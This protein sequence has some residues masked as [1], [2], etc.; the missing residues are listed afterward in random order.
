MNFHYIEIDLPFIFG[1][2][3]SYLLVELIQ[4]YKYY[5][6]ENQLISI[7]DKNCFFYTYE[8]IQ[9]RLP[10]SRCQLDTIIKNLKMKN[11][12]EV[13]KKG[14]PARNYFCLNF[15]I[16]DSLRETYKLECN[17]PTLYKVDMSQTTKQESSIVIVENSQTITQE[18]DDNI[19]NY[20]L[21]NNNNNDILSK[22]NKILKEK[23]I[24]EHLFVDSIYF[25][26]YELFLDHAKDVL[27]KYP[28]VDIKYYFD[29]IGDYEKKGGYKKTDWIGVL[30]TWIRNDIKNKD[31]AKIKEVPKVETKKEVV[32]KLNPEGKRYFL[33]HLKTHQIEDLF[34]RKNARNILQE[35]Y[36][37]ESWIDL[38][39]L[40][41][42]I[43]PKNNFKYREIWERYEPT[44]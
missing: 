41:D 13:F 27:I 18:T 4:K 3:E 11:V 20:L 15:S 5:E 42:S 43:I 29:Q 19:N 17:N 23:K 25:N 40:V 33:Q 26:N 39:Q 36:F 14:L 35:L 16:I 6:K 22:E 1:G 30:R 32:S 9:Q 38:S 8:S 10:F 7:N 24:K 21:N 44:N 12:I 28:N 37:I 31:Y 2:L 34:S